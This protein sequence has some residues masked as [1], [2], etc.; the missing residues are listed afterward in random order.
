MLNKSQ[1]RTNIS[2]ENLQ[3]IT[4]DKF[5]SSFSQ[6]KSNNEINNNLH[7]LQQNLKFLKKRKH[8][9][10]TINL[11]NKKIQLK[12]KNKFITT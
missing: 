2:T 7:Q 1:I 4:S 12:K 11:K 5:L 8:S 10:E 6:M 9:N 3:Q